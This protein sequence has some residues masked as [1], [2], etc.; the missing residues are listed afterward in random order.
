[1]QGRKYL[2]VSC[3]GLKCWELCFGFRLLKC[4]VIDILIFLWDKHWSLEI[5]K[6]RMLKMCDM[7]AI[8]V[9]MLGIQR[10]CHSSAIAG[11]LWV[12]H[13][14]WFKWFD[15][16]YAALHHCRSWVDDCSLQLSGIV[17]AQSDRK[18][19]MSE[20]A[21]EYRFL[22]HRRSPDARYHDDGLPFYLHSNTMYMTRLR[23]EALLPLS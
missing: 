6:A 4:E 8:C 18:M 5:W 20:A 11:P 17:A 15:V 10:S 7:C 12:S 9:N 21:R 23:G 13:L 1:M 14:S 22:A 16:F 19:M 3:W 2:E